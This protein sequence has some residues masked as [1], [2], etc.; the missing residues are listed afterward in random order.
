[1]TTSALPLPPAVGI[2]RRIESATAWTSR[3]LSRPLIGQAVRYA[4]V[5]VTSTGFQLGVYLTLRGVLGPLSANVI[6]LVL[7]NVANT[8]ANRRITFDVRGRRGSLRQQL[9]GLVVLALS[10]G[11]TSAALG[12][13]AVLSPNPSQGAELAVL[14][15]ANLVGT[16]AR[17][18]LLRHWV[19]AARPGAET[20]SDVLSG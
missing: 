1:M 7:S 18:T 19:F 17:F 20:A 12:L 14:V 5:G 15:A 9:Q 8:T 11:L 16:L 2:V 10:L 6:S 3:R 4:A 13:L